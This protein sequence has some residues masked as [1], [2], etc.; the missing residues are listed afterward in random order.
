MSRDL[1]GKVRGRG[2][3]FA[4]REGR[5]GASASLRC[6]EGRSGRRGGMWERK[7]WRR[8]R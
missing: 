3:G 6:R 8:Q 1:H 5:G 2:G 7:R 4:A